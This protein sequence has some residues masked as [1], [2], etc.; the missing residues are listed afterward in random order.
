[1]CS[2]Q[3]VLC[4]VFRLCYMQQLVCAMCSIQ[5]VLCAFVSL[6]YV[7]VAVTTLVA[8]LRTY[9]AS[10]GRAYAC[11]S[12]FEDGQNPSWCADLLGRTF[13]KA[14][15]ETPPYIYIHMYILDAVILMHILDVNIFMHILVDVRF[16]NILDAVMFMHIFESVIFMQILGLVIFMHIPDARCCCVHAYIRC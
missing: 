13:V 14:T 6:C 3:S 4:A 5:S 15:N 2:V 8:S 7:Y 11:M 10:L 12:M 9:L 16:M 1:M